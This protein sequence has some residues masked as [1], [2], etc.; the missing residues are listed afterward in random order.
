MLKLKQPAYAYVDVLTI[1]R[2]GITGNRGLLQKVN[3]AITELQTRARVYEASASTGELYTI[4]PIQSREGDDPVVLGRLKKSDLIKLYGSYLVGKKKPARAIYDA[5]MIAADEKCPFCGGIGRPRNL[6]HYLPKAHYPQFSILPVNLVPSCRDCNMDGKGE[7][8]A[9]AEAEQVIQP[10]LDDERY[11]NEQWLFARYVAGE[12]D[13]PGVIEYYVYPP[14]DWEDSQKRRVEKHFKDF[15]LSLRFSKEAGPRSV[16]LLGQFQ[17][18]L[19]VPIDKDVAKNIIFQT[20]VDN[21]PFVNHW[22]RVMCLA[23]MSDL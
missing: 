1:C 12:G 7:A 8:F 2:D 15:D 22:E 3:D 5:L 20:V 18:L 11:F 6:D 4:Q 17:A 14:E 9:T 19:Q 23:L 21:S 16:S 13:E 10:Y